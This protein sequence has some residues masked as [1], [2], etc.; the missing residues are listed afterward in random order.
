MVGELERVLEVIFQ[1]LDS[2][3]AD[4]ENRQRVHAFLL[5]LCHTV[6]VVT[7]L[8]QAAR[9]LWEAPDEGWHRWA[10]ERFTATLGGAL[11][12]ACQQ[13]CPEMD[14]SDLVLDLDPGP[15]PA[16]IEAPAEGM[17]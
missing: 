2:E 7:A 9:V 8:G 3:D 10:R 1:T 16:G 14:A 12:E 11:M 5:R 4:E 13:S 15:R 17:P 6:D